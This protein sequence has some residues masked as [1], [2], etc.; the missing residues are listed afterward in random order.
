MA[1][2]RMVSLVDH[3]ARSMRRALADIA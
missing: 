1:Y 3:V 2:P